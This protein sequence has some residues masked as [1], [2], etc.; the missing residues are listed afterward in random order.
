MAGGPERPADGGGVEGL[1]S[2][3]VVCQS[4]LDSP[5]KALAGKRMEDCK[6]LA[7]VGCEEERAQGVGGGLSDEGG[8]ALLSF[9]AFDVSS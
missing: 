5:L 6:G 9:C 7:P 8:G 3:L 4:C 1:R 2:R